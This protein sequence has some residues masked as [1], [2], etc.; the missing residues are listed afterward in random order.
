SQATQL[1]HL[2]PHLLGAARKRNRLDHLFD[3]L[4]LTF[5]HFLEFVRIRK[6]RR[7]LSREILGSLEAFFEAPGAILQR[8][9]HRERAR[10][11]ASLVEGHEE[12][13]RTCTWILA[14]G[15]GACALPLH[16]PGHFA[17]QLELG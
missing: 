3:A 11:Q 12:A 13:D 6:I 16:K 1:L 14:F 7:R 4:A 17:V 5:L 8:A 15:G 10:C 9:A 2:M